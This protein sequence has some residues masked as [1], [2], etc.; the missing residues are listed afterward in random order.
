MSTNTEE[1]YPAGTCKNAVKINGAFKTP[2]RQAPYTIMNVCTP[3]HRRM[4]PL[5]YKYVF[6][7]VYN[8]YLLGCR[9]GELYLNLTSKGGYWVWVCSHFG[10]VVVW[11]KLATAHL[12]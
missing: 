10:D 6:L 7:A 11:P 9:R 1:R 8:V 2:G 12:F 3:D 5:C 4:A